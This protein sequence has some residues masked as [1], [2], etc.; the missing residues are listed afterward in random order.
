MTL[1]QI[2]PQQ[3]PASMTLILM[4]DWS[5]TSLPARRASSPEGRV[6]DPEGAV[7]TDT[8]TDRN[9]GNGR[10]VEGLNM[11]NRERKSFSPE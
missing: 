5:P 10:D 9:L 11:K 1:Y 3:V 4:G 8:E 6:Y 2:N 7:K